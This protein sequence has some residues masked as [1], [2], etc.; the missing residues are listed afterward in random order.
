MSN[1]W[2][3]LNSV[4]IAHRLSADPDTVALIPVGATEQHGPHLPVGT[5]TIMATAVAEAA[6]GE[7]ALV[8]PAIAFGASFFHGT[9]LPGTVAFDGDQTATAAVRVAEACADSGV[10]R[11]LFVNGHVGNSAPL[12]LACDR[13]RRHHPDRRIGVMQWWDLTPDI[14]RRATEDALDWHANAAETSLMLAVRPELVDVDAMRDADDPDRTAGTV[15]R[16]PVQQVSTNGVT[17]Y[18]SRASK[19]Y[20]LQLW[21]D[22]VAAARDVVMRAHSEVPPLG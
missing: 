14:A 6:A 21:A 9:A 19:A 18:P 16:Y 12:W 20:G 3:D 4:Q 15:F 5:D 10:R 17:G 22:V 7:H 8:L 1:R 11:V 13:F 2:E